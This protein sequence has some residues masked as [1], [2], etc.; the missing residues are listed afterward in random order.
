MNVAFI[1]QGA[2]FAL[3]SA[4]VV[5]TLRPGR[6]AVAFL[7]FALLYGAGSAT[8][9]LFPSGGT[10]TPALIHF[11]GAAAAILSGNLAVIAAGV[12]WCRSRFRV[13]GFT[14]ILLG[15]AGL[16]SGG[17][18]LCH[19]M[20]GAQVFFGAGTWERGAV[21]PIISWQLLVGI[22]SVR[23]RSHRESVPGINE[24]AGR[25]ATNGMAGG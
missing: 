4:L 2:A 12:L 6:G 7:G 20:L 17:L 10:G 5:A 18:L 16:L 13:I 9:G 23:W 11:G 15:V 14:S 25:T 8:V 1:T 24:D 3:A 21:Y 22:R 19:S